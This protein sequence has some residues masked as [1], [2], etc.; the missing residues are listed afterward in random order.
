MSTSGVRAWPEM[1]TCSFSPALPSMAEGM[2]GMGAAPS[3][4]E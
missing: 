3:T 4:T 2:A 1:V